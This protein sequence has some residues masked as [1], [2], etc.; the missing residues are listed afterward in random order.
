MVV[1]GLGHGRRTSGQNACLSVQYAPNSGCQIEIE[2]SD[3]EECEAGRV[4][5]FC[6]VAPPFALSSPQSKRVGQTALLHGL[7]LRGRPM[8][9]G[10]I[11]LK[12]NDEA[13]SLR[14]E[15][16]EK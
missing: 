3:L 4:H 11:V 14:L 2:E 9:I 13:Q 15:D 7:G 6:C 8:H 12:T 5:P 16:I 1:R 10:S